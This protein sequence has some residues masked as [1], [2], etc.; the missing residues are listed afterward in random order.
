MLSIEERYELFQNTLEECGIDILKES[1]DIIEYQ[2]FEEFAVDAISFLHENML[3]TLLCEGLIDDD[4]YEKC[5]NLRKLYLSMQ[6]DLLLLN[7]D[8]VKASAEWK[9]L[10]QLSDEIRQQLFEG[11]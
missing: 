9:K 7:A 6:P 3:D 11:T 1:D 4:I 10:M 2:L 8:G 5:K